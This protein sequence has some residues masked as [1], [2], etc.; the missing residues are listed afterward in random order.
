MFFVRSQVSIARIIGNLPSKISERTEP[1]AQ[2]STLH[3]S[4]L[5]LVS[6]DKKHILSKLEYG[7]A[8]SKPAQFGDRDIAK[9]EESAIFA[10]RAVAVHLFQSMQGRGD[11]PSETR[12]RDCLTVLVFKIGD[13]K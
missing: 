4:Q 5:R 13:C 6:L 7:E 10:P 1:N 11:I 8:E 2:A 9:H 3:E 12:S